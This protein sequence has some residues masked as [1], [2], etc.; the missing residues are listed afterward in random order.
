MNDKVV[1]EGWVKPYNRLT[2]STYMVVDW[3]DQT[4]RN[5]KRLTPYAKMQAAIDSRLNTP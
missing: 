1:I 3:P 2:S 5:Q 4:E